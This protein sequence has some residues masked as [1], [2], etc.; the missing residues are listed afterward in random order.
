MPCCASAQAG[1][2]SS[3][4]RNWA[5]ASSFLPC[6]SRSVPRPAFGWAQAGSSSAARRN[7]ASARAALEPSA[8]GIEQQVWASLSCSVASA[9][10][11]G[12]CS[13]RSASAKRRS[14]RRSLTS[15][16]SAVAAEAGGGGEDRT[17]CSS[18]STLAWSLAS[19]STR[20]RP[21]AAPSGALCGSNPS[22]WSPGAGGASTGGSGARSISAEGSS[23]SHGWRE[24]RRRWKGRLGPGP[25]DARSS[26]IFAS[27]C[28][29]GSCVLEA[30]AARITR[31]STGVGGACTRS[32]ASCISSSERKRSRRS[33]IALRMTDASG[34]VS[35][36]PTSPES[37]GGVSVTSSYP[38]APAA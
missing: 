24:R 22:R 31:S 38:S 35:S 16:A 9:A 13:A 20:G 7:A 15:R 10:V 6:L 36:G 18:S 2:T 32:T 14:S 26:S 4:A 27:F 5:S 25:P 33:L 11:S 3:A 37:R 8:S 12:D 30:T 19:S 21:C 34:P 17:C 28:A 1:S 29:G 23:P